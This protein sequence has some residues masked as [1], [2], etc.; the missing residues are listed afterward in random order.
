MGDIDGAVE[1]NGHILWLE[2]KRGAVM[3]AFERQHRA[4]IRMAEAFT[5]NSERQTFVFVLGDPVTMEVERFRII[6]G[7]AWRKGWHDGGTERFKDF[8]RH[9]FVRADGGLNLLGRAESG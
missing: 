4:Q 1:R 8:L 7:G 3:D 2:W 5:R 6:H 9:W